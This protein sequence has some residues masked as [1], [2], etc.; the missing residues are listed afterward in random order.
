[1]NSD[2]DSVCVALEGIELVKWDS[3]SLVTRTVANAVGKQN[4]IHHGDMQL[5]LLSRARQ[6]SNIE[7][8]TA[9]R[10][11][12]VETESKSVILANQE[13]IEGHDLVIVADGVKSALKTKI[14]LAEAAYAKPTGEA[15]YRFT[16]DRS[17]LEPDAE[18]LAF[19]QHS[20][21]T[22]WDGSARHVVAYPVRNHQL[23][24]V[25]LIHPDDGDISG[26]SW[27]SVTDKQNV[28]ADFQGWDP[29]LMRLIALAPAQVPNFRMFAHPPSP[30]WFKGAT[31]LLGDACHAM[32][33]VPPLNPPCL[34][35]AD[36]FQ[37]IPR[38][39]RC[40]GGRRLGRHRCSTFND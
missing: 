10:V 26:E 38:P 14:C 2:N 5:A 36:L 22:R 9:V 8:R 25:V 11:L 27:T 33:F 24:N 30:S 34:L 3:G 35:Q 1:M 37:A 39:G 40:P 28:V 17:L 31:V 19:V 15:A 13:R 6:L 16:L 32:L 4:A 29:R 12:D 7:I 23:L 18:L 21:A 20:W